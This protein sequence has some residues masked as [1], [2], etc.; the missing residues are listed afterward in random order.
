MYIFLFDIGFNFDFI[1]LIDFKVDKLYIALLHPLC[2]KM[3]THVYK[4]MRCSGGD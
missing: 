1:T 4:I 2:S 3:D